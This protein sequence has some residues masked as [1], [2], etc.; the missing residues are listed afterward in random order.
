M[1][2]SFLLL[3]LV[4]VCVFLPGEEIDFSIRYLGIGV[5]DVCMADTTL[6]ECRQ[7]KVTALSTS[8]AGLFTEMDNTYISQY[9]GDYLPLR[10][11]KNINQYRYREDRTISY[12]RRNLLAMRESRI[13]ST[14]CRQYGIM[15]DSRDFFSALYYLRKA[16]FDTL[17]SMPLDA[18]ALI[19]TAN[20]SIDARETIST[21]FGKKETI[22]VRIDF[23]RTTDGKKERSDMLTNKL[24]DE[25]VPMYIW[26]TDDKRRLP[27]KAKFDSSPFPVT[28]AMT[29][30]RE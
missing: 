15:A 11:I 16:D 18:N 7:L 29:G 12:D 20:I 8:L 19:W 9:L 28:W 26:F 1:K 27:V 2:S 17:R 25:E 30:Y 21:M 10:Y 13:D 5:V 14:L 23:R 4:S 24:V 6:Q 22:K 3:L